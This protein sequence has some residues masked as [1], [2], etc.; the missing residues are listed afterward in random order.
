MLRKTEPELMNEAEQATAYANADF[1]E[2]HNHFIDLLKV[3]S[4]DGLPDKGRALD[5]GCGAAD[6][7]IRF[8]NAFPAYYVDAID[9]AEAMLLEAEKR[10]TNVEKN[11]SKRIRLIESELQTYQP[12]SFN[13]DILFSNSL[14]HHLYDPYVLWT[15]IRQFPADTNVFIMDLMRPD[16]EMQVEKLVKHYA[17]AEPE[18]LQRDFRNSLFAAFR[19]DEIKTQLE[20]AQL[21]ELE[22]EV[23]SDRHLVIKGKLGK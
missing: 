15:F 8:A 5:V 16:N 11:V 21:T 3:A 17:H 9:G 18:I 12:T 1:D 23:V 19:P 14:L 6:I 2:P 22:V 10:L 4:I 20:Q 7:S 13:Y